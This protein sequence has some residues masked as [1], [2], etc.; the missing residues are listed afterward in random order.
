MLVRSARCDRLLTSRTILPN[1]GTAGSSMS[2]SAYFCPSG[3][4]TEGS[5]GTGIDRPSGRRAVLWGSERPSRG[6]R[7][8]NVQKHRSVFVPGA[9]GG[10]LQGCSFGRET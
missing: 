5:N 7:R 2:T 9:Q 3:L 10:S 4:R 1:C 6:V 8:L